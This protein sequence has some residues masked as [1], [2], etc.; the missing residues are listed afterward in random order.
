MGTGE[1]EGE[2]PDGL[3]RGRGAPL[4][5]FGRPF[6][7]GALHGG[8]GELGGDEQGAGRGEEQGQDQQERLAHR[9]TPA[10]VGAYDG[11]RGTAG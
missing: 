9:V 5:D 4:T 8:E 6:D 1:L 3:E 7:G 11:Q 10:P 2:P